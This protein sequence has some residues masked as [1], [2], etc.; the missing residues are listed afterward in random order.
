MALADA[1]VNIPSTTR[2]LSF[3]TDSENFFNVQF[4]LKV[5]EIS[6]AA[7]AIA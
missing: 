6:A 5:S 7:I 3:E 1:F 4:P 2:P